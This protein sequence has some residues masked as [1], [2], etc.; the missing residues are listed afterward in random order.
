MVRKH[1][2]NC[3][4]QHIQIISVKE[5]CQISMS[6]SI[7]LQVSQ[8]SDEKVQYLWTM[9][10]RSEAIWCLYQYEIEREEQVWISPHHINYQKVAKI[11]N[12]SQPDPYLDLF[13]LPWPSHL[14][15]FQFF[16]RFSAFFPSFAYNLVLSR[17][18]KSWSLV[19]YNSNYTLML[20]ISGPA[21]TE[22]PN[23]EE[24]DMIANTIKKTKYFLVKYFFCILC[25]NH[26]KQAQP[27]F[28]CS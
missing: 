13:V 14:I 28:H 25:F 9:F 22:I 15:N 12:C 24:H 20:I 19:Q 6:A 27:S 17:G 11:I 2:R 23:V 16:K 1:L 5:F 26:P 8:C 4:N 3:Q 21:S 10:A 18:S 7:L